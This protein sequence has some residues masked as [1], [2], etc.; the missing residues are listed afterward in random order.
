[1]LRGATSRDELE[2]VARQWEYSLML[3]LL[4]PHQ[5]IRLERL[6][7]ELDDRFEA[8]NQPLSSIE[9]EYI[10][11]THL[12]EDE[13]VDESKQPPSHFQDELEESSGAPPDKDTPAHETDERGYE[14]FT[15]QSG[16]SYY[17]PTG[18]GVPWVKFEN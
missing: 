4:G 12:V 17:R 3:R 14:W 8:Q 9:S 2:D 13:L 16:V 7:A 1:M 10:D 5:G 15:D 11:H 18:S 6:R